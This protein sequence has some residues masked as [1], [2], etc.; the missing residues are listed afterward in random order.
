MF[1]LLIRNGLIV[2]GTGAE[3]RLGDIAIHDGLLAQVGG[4]VE[5][6][7]TQE[8]D[9]SGRIVTPGFVDIHT[10]Y[11]GEAFFDDTLSP[12]NGH[13]VTTVVLGVCGIGFAP[14][15][16]DA[17]ELLV[18]TMESVEDIPGD[19]LRAGLPWNWETFPEFL[20][21]LEARHYSVDVAAQI[22]HVPLR[23][24]V[25]GERALE[26]G[27]ATQADIAQMATLVREAIEAGAVGFSTSRVVSHTTGVGDP[28]PGTFAAE[29]ELFGIAA[30]IAASGRPAV[31][32]IAE[33]G[34]DGF[35][36]EKA[37]KEVDWMRRL[38]AEFS[39][40]VSFLV[41]QSPGAPDLWRE[42]MDA[43]EDAKAD[44][45]QLRPQ[46]ANRPFGML[47]GLRTRH[48]FLKRATYQRLVHETGSFEDLRAE[49]AKPEVRAAILAEDDTVDSGMPFE[50]MGLLAKAMPQLVFPLSEEPDYEPPEDDSLAARAAAQGV[51]P[52]EV[53]YDLMLRFDGNAL[54]LVPFFNYVRGNQDDI[55]EMLT[56]PAAL[57]GLADGGAHLA[58]ICDASMPTYQL[59]HWV[60]GR[61]RGRRLPLEFAV[62]MQ[63]HD[64][65]QFY[66][67]TDRGTLEVGKKADL[68]V[69]DLER[70]ALLMPS[71]VPDLP[72]GASRIVQ[73]AV[74]YDATIVSGVVTRLDD[75]DTGA[76]PG[77]L[78]RACR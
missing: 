43:C 18:T 21:A 72:T 15:R 9:A 67:L 46:V 48:P 17:H 20:D 10:H 45:A 69:I 6:E 7:A 11:D 3:P 4:A 51:E 63:T 31:F 56:H 1:D 64:T 37:L 27:P 53:F 59:S 52:L 58:T 14:A 76:R 13:G 26:N 25:M 71:V 77:R 33:A 8:V 29:D 75:Q 41:L 62:K 55:Y 16:Q 38:S 23:T 61:T 24:F 44:G 22:G 19:V 30:G 57:M 32:Q 36:P 2:D 60:K 49:M 68:N 40:P 50:G 5:G 42:L 28:V 35:E 78:V 47:L 66:G 34:T 54:F 39:L 12:S 73:R 70:L 65:A 74:G